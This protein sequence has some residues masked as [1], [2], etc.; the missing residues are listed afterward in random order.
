MAS[1]N[2]KLRR[3]IGNPD[4]VVLIEH[5]KLRSVWIYECTENWIWAWI[6]DPLA[7]CHTLSY[8]IGKKLDI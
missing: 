6:G 5:I 7:F 1:H 3:A 8:E 2:A 4:A